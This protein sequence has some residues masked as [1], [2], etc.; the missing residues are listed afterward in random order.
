M[1]NGILNAFLFCLVFFSQREETGLQ[2]VAADIEDVVEAAQGLKDVSEM[3]KSLCG[4]AHSTMAT[5][6]S[7]S[8]AEITTL[9]EVFC[10]L[11]CKG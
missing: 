2:E 11:I 4:F 1:L 8:V 7:F 3:L 6:H 10:C 9:K 5:T